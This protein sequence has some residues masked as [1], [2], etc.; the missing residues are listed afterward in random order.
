MCEKC[1]I[2]LQEKEHSA[3]PYCRE[4]LSVRPSSLARRMISSIKTPC[5]HE[6]GEKVQQK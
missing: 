3:C 5:K 6:C 4:S 1:S 2:N